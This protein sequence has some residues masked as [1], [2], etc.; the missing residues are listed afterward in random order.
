MFHQ[1]I[2]RQCAHQI[3]CILNENKWFVDTCTHK[4][5]LQLHV[6]RGT[7]AIVRQ[8]LGLV[9]KSSEVDIFFNK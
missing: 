6:K 9:R 3:R 5:L 2:Q 4:Y 8:V 7:I 1:Y